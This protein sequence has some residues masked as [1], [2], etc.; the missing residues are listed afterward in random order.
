MFARQWFSEHW[1]SVSVFL[2]RRFRGCRL[3]TTITHKLKPATFITLCCEL[4]SFICWMHCWCTTYFYFALKTC[5]CGFFVLH[6]NVCFSSHLFT[7]SSSCWCGAC[8]LLMQTVCNL[9]VQ[10]ITKL[11]EFML[12]VFLTETTA[13]AHLQKLPFCVITVFVVFSL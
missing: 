11:K 1:F 12:I 5:L 6:A 2:L 9:Y 3:Y 4:L 10:H 8:F 13:F 7:F